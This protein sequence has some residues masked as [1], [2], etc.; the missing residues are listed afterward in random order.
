[1]NVFISTVSYQFNTEIFNIIVLGN[2][3]H[4]TTSEICTQAIGTGVDVL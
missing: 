4:G 1:M 2:I 3:P